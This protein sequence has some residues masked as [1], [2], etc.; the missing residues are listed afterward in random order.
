MVRR[1]VTNTPLQALALMND[2][3]Y[4]EASRKLAERM[5][6][7]AGKSPSERIQFAYRLCVS[8]RGH[9]RRAENRKVICLTI[10]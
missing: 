4:V 10:N 8:R 5:L 3:T 7:E 6:T 2:P 1:S 9:A